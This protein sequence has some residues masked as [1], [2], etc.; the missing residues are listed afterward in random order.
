MKPVPVSSCLEGIMQY[1]YIDESGSM[2]DQYVD[3]WPYFVV[4]IV[5]AENPQRLRSVR[6][7]FIRKYMEE[8]KAADKDGRMFNDGAFKELKGQ[9]FTPE[10]KRKFAEYFFREGTLDVFYIIIDNKKALS[11]FYTNKARAFNYVFKLAFEYFVRNKQLPDDEYAIQF[12]ERNERPDA[13]HFLQNYLNTELRMEGVLSK[14]VHVKYFDSSQNHI[15][16]IADVLANLYFSHLRTG[17]YEKEFQQM[18]ESGGLK[19]EFKFPLSRE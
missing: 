9:A 5:R 15:I 7:R 1:L 18:R 14:D 6:K 10:L 11:N 17:A 8:L 3:D 12:D 16:Q 13:R 4:A 19:F 2:T